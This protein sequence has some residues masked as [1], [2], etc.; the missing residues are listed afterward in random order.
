MELYKK[1]KGGRL[2]GTHSE[3]PKY[4]KIKKPKRRHSFKLQNTIDEIA[5]QVQLI[6]KKKELI[7]IQ[8]ISFQVFDVHENYVLDRYPADQQPPIISKE[9]H[10]HCLGHL[11]NYIGFTNIQIR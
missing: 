8:A 2:K 7:T 6:E 10:M 4:E 11:K 5:P 9:I 1:G 3:P